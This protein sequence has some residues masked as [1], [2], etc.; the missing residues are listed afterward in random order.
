MRLVGGDGDQSAAG[1]IDLATG[2]EAKPCM[3]C[4][5]FEKDTSRLA[6]HLL[7]QGLVPDAAGYFETPIARDFKGRRSLRLH[8]RD[9]GWCRKNCQ[10]VDMLATCEE[11]SPVTTRAEL[12]SRIR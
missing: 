8:P 9:H 3:N 5:S 4:R 6:R 11:W 2:F 10:V 7:S 12:A 1:V